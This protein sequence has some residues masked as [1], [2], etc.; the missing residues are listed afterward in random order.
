MAAAEFVAVRVTLVDPVED[1]EAERLRERVDMAEFV[2]V[3][4]AER[5][6]VPEPVV[7]AVSRRLRLA[8][9][10]VVGLR[11]RFPEFEF[12]GLA[13]GVRLVR[14]DAVPVLE[15]GAVPVEVE[16]TDPLSVSS[17]VGLL[18]VSR[19]VLGEAVLVLEGR[20]LAVSETEGRR[21]G[22]AER[23]LGGVRVWS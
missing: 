1:F 19:E 16:L 23:V 6:V 9:P 10:V 2:G 13:V 18:V 17:V 20:W 22:V 15:G 11:E 7:E 14:D 3:D 8:E 21:L 5:L 12:V 4:E